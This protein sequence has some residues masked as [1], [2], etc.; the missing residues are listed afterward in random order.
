MW[1]KNRPGFHAH[2]ENFHIDM[3]F[4]IFSVRDEPERTCET[5]PAVT[6]RAICARHTF[7]KTVDWQNNL[8]KQC[9]GRN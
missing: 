9:Q 4:Q 5:A 8:L 3:I 6:W 2:E 7:W 1:R